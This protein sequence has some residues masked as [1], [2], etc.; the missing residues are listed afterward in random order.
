MHARLFEKEYWYKCPK[1]GCK[2]TFQFSNLLD[3]HIRI[4]ENDLDICS[5]CP[6]RYADP[7]QYKRHLK[8]HF[9]IRD[10]ECDQCDLKFAR[11]GDLNEHYQKHEGISYSCLICNDYTNSFKS[12]IGKHMRVKHADIVG[13]N[14]TWNI[15]LNHV[16]IK[17]LS[18]A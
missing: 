8:M 15:L 9:R 5:Y 17:K 1:S 14:F 12:G 4:H 18:V 7:A 10:F 13:K 11:Q 2:S 6:Y 16:E 3:L